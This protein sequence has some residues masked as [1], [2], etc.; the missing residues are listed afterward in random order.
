M[1]G[2]GGTLM[3]LLLLLIAVRANDDYRPP[4]VRV[5]HRESLEI[6]HSILLTH[7]NS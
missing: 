2:T 4:S 1:E 7:A 3:F 5:L 6:V